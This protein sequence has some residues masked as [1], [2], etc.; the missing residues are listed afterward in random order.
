ME[1]IKSAQV[2]VKLV[3]NDGLE[4]EVVFVFEP[5]TFE[6]KKIEDID[7][8]CCC[9]FCQTTPKAQKFSITGSVSCYKILT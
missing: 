3:Y 5:Q 8:E 4:R 2:V 7:S 1:D 6:C 9:E